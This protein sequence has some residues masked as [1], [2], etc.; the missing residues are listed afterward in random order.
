M[1]AFVLDCSIAMAWC[2]EDEASAETDEILTRLRD[3]GANAPALWKWEVANVLN[4]AV[5]RGRLGPSDVAARVD[6]LATLPIAIDGEGAARAWRETLLI[7]Q[8]EGL[9]VYDAAYL[10][11][12]VRLGF[13]LSSK[14]K[15]L[16]AAA[17]RRGL[18]VCP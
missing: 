4:A 9:T 6:L 14:D 3:H 17:A 16:R 12:A 8:A 15:D 7:A 2:F 10:E 5:K 1:S 18:E 11:L 13:G